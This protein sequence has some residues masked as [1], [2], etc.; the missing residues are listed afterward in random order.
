MKISKCSQNV[1]L[2]AYCDSPI[3]HQGIPFGFPSSSN[4]SLQVVL[5]TG[6]SFFILKVCTNAWLI[7]LIRAGL[8]SHVRKAG[9]RLR[10]S[11]LLSCLSDNQSKSRTKPC[12]FSLECSIPISDLPSVPAYKAIATLHKDLCTSEGNLFWPPLH[13][14]HHLD[15]SLIVEGLKSNFPSIRFLPCGFLFMEHQLAIRRNVENSPRAETVLPVMLLIS[16]AVSW[17]S[18]A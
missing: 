10:D 18:E 15:L 9:A 12:G 14:S 1:M 8:A 7:A 5:T 17:S 6:S 2:A 16:A 4:L 3:C 13:P 11:W